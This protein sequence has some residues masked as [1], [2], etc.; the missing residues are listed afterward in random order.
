MRILGIDPGYAI[1]GYGVLE[2]E[3]GKTRFL[4]CGVIETHAGERI[5]KRLK[6]IHDSTRELIR[7]FAPDACA[8]EELFFYSN[9]TTGIN[10]A[11]ARGVL[12]CACEEERLKVF[13]YTPMQVKSAVVG[14]GRAQKAQVMEMTRVLLK[15]PGVPKPDDAAD[16][17]AVAL[18]HAHFAQSRLTPLQE[19]LENAKKTAGG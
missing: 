6:F 2:T 7:R 10:V 4:D 16:A 18:C 14:Y 1:V 15:L 3:R 8:M 5:E 17:L 19:K 12:L 9:Q 13:E 11:Q